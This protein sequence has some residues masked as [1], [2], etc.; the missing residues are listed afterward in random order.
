MHQ[1]AL[2][3][4]VRLIA[5]D[6]PG[7]GGSDHHPERRIADWA[8][9]LAAL[10]DHL[11]LNRFALLGLSGG[12]PYALAGAWHLEE[13][14]QK[15]AL[16]CPLGPIA[17]PTLMQQMQWSARLNLAFAQRAPQ[18]AHWLYGGLTAQLLAANPHW[19]EKM[20]TWSAP[21]SDHAALASGDTLAI[22][23]QTIIDAMGNG[24]YGARCDLLLY[25]QPWEIPLTAI[26]TP[27]D[28]WH[29]DADG[30][31]PLGHAH[32]YAAQLPQVALYER[33][34]HGHY[35]LPLQEAVSILRTLIHN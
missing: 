20:R 29:G 2:A 31:V 9:D 26:Q 21:P 25:T 23:R 17:Q 1:A 5:A 32:W 15:C 4:Q 22:L 10:A 6:R 14:V 34:G 3:T 12:G 27:I 24:A 18:L 28:I 13:R 8:H 16:V 35:S 11:E 19:V 33:P 7:Y 30:T